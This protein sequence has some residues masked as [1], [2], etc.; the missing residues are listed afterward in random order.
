[1]LPAE[2]GGVLWAIFSL[3]I[4]TVCDQSLNHRTGA[5]FVVP[6]PSHSICKGKDCSGTDSL[7]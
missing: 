5:G 7:A 6:R 4:G 3:F 2:N 1:M